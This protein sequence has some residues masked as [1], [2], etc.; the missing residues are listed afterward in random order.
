MTANLPPSSERSRRLTREQY[1]ELGNRGFFDGKRV[2]LIFG[3]VVEM[4]PINWPH[5]L[6]VGLVTDVLRVAFAPGYWVNVQQPF[7]VLGLAFG[8]EP[9]P[10]VAVILG[11]KRDYTDHPTVAA[12][13]VEVADATLSN[14]LTT[15]AELYATANVPEYWVLDVAN[16]Q[17]FRNP[18]PL[19]AGL[20]ATA[21]TSHTTLAPTDTVSPLAA[22]VLRSWLV[23]FCREH[24]PPRCREPLC[25]LCLKQANSPTLSS[26]EVSAPR[27]GGRVVDCAAL[28]MLC[29]GNRTEGSNPSLSA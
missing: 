22:Q 6:G 21:Y 15:K 12:L 27:R 26:A 16:R 20:E 1:Y 7:S 28:E 18:A 11:T 8:S 14:D 10:D 17:L 23:I 3:E 2:E 19:A 5:A 4:S 25:L 9:Q 24:E 13:I 29:T